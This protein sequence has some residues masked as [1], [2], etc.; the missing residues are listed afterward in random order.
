[1]KGSRTVS[2]VSPIDV[3]SRYKKENTRRL[4]C[5]HDVKQVQWAV[6]TGRFGREMSQE[7]LQGC[8]L[9]VGI[10]LNIH[11][12]NYEKDESTVALFYSGVY[13]KN[14]GSKM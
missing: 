11:N 5:K 12:A 8:L 14:H 13:S 3:L 9:Y 1:M 7:R 2:W 10:S 6:Y 4:K